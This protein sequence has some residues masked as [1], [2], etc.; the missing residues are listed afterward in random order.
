MGLSKTVTDVWFPSAISNDFFF[1][2]AE[3]EK[4]IGSIPSESRNF[5]FQTVYCCPKD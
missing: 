2:F 5:H 3:K 1:V 4:E